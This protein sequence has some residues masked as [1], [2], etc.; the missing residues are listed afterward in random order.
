MRLDLHIHTTFSDGTR[1]PE[2]V[3][4]LAVAGDL[5]VIAITDHD[6][7]LGVKPAQRAA[8]GKIRVISGAEMSARWRGES[9]HVLGYFVDPDAQALADHYRTL[10]ARRHVRMQRIVE[11]L[12]AQGVGLPLAR[13]DDQRADGSVPYTRPHLARAL[14]WAGHAF[15]IS[16]AFDRYIGDGCPAYVQTE[17]PGPEEVISTIHAAGGV[18]VWAHPPLR[19]VD[20]LLPRMIGAGLRGMEVLRPWA[21]ATREAMAA[22]ARRAGL[23]ATGG[24]DWHGRDDD[25]E[26]GDFF[27]L[28]EDVVGFLAAG[29][30]QLRAKAAREVC[31]ALE[32][33]PLP[34][35]E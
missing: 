25:G 14:V 5:D 11:R 28:A 12:E 33:A 24:S 21:P 19:L 6:S 13:V 16:D 8:E 10:H 34:E 2:E 35:S 22:H 23:F 26:L 3:V 18:A 17:S 4:S 20:E 32:P 9:I 30:M 7:A 31:R 27:V 29:A 15:S 1:T